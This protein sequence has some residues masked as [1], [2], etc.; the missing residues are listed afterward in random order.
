MNR[1]NNLSIERALKGHE[2]VTIRIVDIIVDIT[3][4]GHDEV[5]TADCLLTMKK[6][7]DKTDS[8]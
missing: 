5:F 6:K 1:N 3:N 7:K 4:I 8:I 2:K